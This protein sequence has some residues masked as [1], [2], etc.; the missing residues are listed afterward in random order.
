MNAASNIT[1]K[2]AVQ[3]AVKS[4]AK[5]GLVT[6]HACGLLCRRASAQEAGHCPR[7]GVQLASRHHDCIQR[8][9]ALL[10]AAA[11]CY[12]PANLLPV[13]TTNEPG[14]IETNTIVGGVISLYTS[15]SWFLALIVLVASVVIPLAKLVALVYL[16]LNAQRSPAPAGGGS[17]ERTRMFRGIEFIGRWSMLDVFV[18]SFVAAVLQLE[19]VLSAQVGPG[20]PFFAAVVILTMFA[21]M[22]FDPRLMW[23][24]WDKRD[25]RDKGDPW[26]GG[27]ALEGEGRSHG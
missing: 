16:L 22:S 3:S 1:V 12:V 21:A 10:I 5:E 6:C 24:K 26:N 18:V 20:I 13:L 15:G 4:A 27:G 25:R 9:W 14:D 19:P 2:S 17:R 8:T 23:D 11:I 7:C